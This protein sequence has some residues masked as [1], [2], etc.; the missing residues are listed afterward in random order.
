MNCDM[1]VSDAILD[2]LQGKTVASSKL[3]RQLVEDLLGDG[4]LV[5]IVHKS[6][7]SFR[8]R[9]V[10]T[11]RKA[12]ED[13]DESYRVL[14]V[15]ADGSRAS[16]ASST[17]N[18]KLMTV[19]SCPGFPV[20]AYEK[21]GCRL[22]GEEFVICHN[23]GCFTFICDWRQFEVPEDI[24]IVGVENMENFRK[25]RLQKNLFEQVTASEKIL[26]VS[27]YPQS[28]DL[29]CWLQSIPNRYVHFGDFDLAGINIFLTEFYKYLGD[30]AS[31][32]IPSD[33]ESRLQQ[34]SAK[35][36]NDQNARF[37]HLKAELPYL[38]SLIDSINKYHKCYDQEGYIETYKNEN[39]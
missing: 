5:P 7:K 21:I 17:G 16:L 8:A 31:F 34:G 2:L 23:D 32:L 20:N 4:L 22:N 10:E 29:R 27:R 37:G 19:R 35:R 28:T 14:E 24:V 38:Q 26:F 6:R 13:R 9:N 1:A 18:S 36:Y 3:N 11:L 15:S 25:I 39:E 33:I 30:R 12:L